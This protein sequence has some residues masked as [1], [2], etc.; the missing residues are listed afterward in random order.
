M[1][2][3][4]KIKQ[5]INTT[6]FICVLSLFISVISLCLAYPKHENLCFDY[7]GIFVGILSILVTVLIGWN[8]YTLIDLRNIQNEIK[9]I[10]LEA[11]SMIQK[12]LHLSQSSSWMLYYYLLFHDDPMGLEYRFLYQ[13]V[14]SLLHT[15]K[16]NDFKSCQRI[17]KLMI[18]GLEQMKEC[19]M[20]ESSKKEILKLMCKVNDPEK[21][22]RFYELLDKISVSV[23]VRQNTID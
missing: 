17:V 23:K 15:S 6:L 9:I 12:T 18:R 8:I 19:I 4:K 14:S 13:G 3:N 21:I 5:G 20:S 11:N 22:D 16:C 1:D 10:E 7:Q 2:Q